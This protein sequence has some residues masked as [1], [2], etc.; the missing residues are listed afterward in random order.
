[1]DPAGPG[2]PRDAASAAPAPAAAAP[3]PAAA[4]GD[5]SSQP[6]LSH[7]EEPTPRYVSET[8]GTPPPT[9][10]VEGVYPLQVL[11]SSSGAPAAAA[12]AVP[13]A[14]PHAGD[15]SPV[16][17][18]A[19]SAG[20]ATTATGHH[21]FEVIEID[22][23]RNVLLYR[24]DEAVESP[25]DILLTPEPMDAR[26]GARQNGLSSDE[27]SRKLSD[28]ARAALDEVTSRIWADTPSWSTFFLRADLAI[29]VLQII[30][31]IAYLATGPTPAT[32]D[33]PRMVTGGLG[34]ELALLVALVAWNAFLF[35][36]QVEAP[37]RQVLIRAK[38][39]IDLLSRAGLN[40]V[41]EIKIPSVPSAPIVKVVRDGVV[42]SIPAV[43][44][45]E[46][47]IVELHFG[48]LA[49]AACK[50][51]YVTKHKP[52]AGDRPEYA[53]DSGQGFRPTL[54]GV[55]P[56]Q[57]MRLESQLNHGRFQFRLTATPVVP[58]LMS[59]AQARPR[60]VMTNQLLRLQAAAQR[61]IL[62]L[63]I[64]SLAVALVRHY[65]L[66]H[67]T[68]LG[69]AVAAF[70]VVLPLVPLLVPTL[71][72]L[73]RS[74][75][76]AHV[77]VLWEE[78]QT[79]KTDYEDADEDEFDVEAPPPTKE[80]TLAKFDVLA[81]AL[82]I[83]TS[84]L[85]ESLGSITVLC[86]VDREGTL[87]EAFPSVD[88]IFVPP[89]AILDVGY[90]PDGR[91][92]FEDRDWAAQM[93][94]LK[95]L[96]LAWMC[97][98][99]CDLRKTEPHRN[100][101]ALHIHA[102][103]KASRQTC[104]CPLARQI[105][106]LGPPDY[107]VPVKE[108]F[109]LAPYHPSLDPLQDGVGEEDEGQA[110]SA[111]A[112]GKSTARSMTSLAALRRRGTATS[113]PVAPS[114]SGG[115]IPEADEPGG[116]SSGDGPASHHHASHH[117]HGGEHDLLLEYDPYHAPADPSGPMV[118]TLPD[119]EFEVP[120]LHTMLL[121]DARSGHHQLISAGSVESIL[122]VA[123]DVWLG[124]DLVPLTD[125]Q[126][127][128]I[129][130]WYWNTVMNDHQIVA[131]AYKPVLDA[132]TCFPG[133]SGGVGEDGADAFVYLEIPHQ[134]GGGGGGGAVPR[135]GSAEELGAAGPAAPAPP[136]PPPIP[137]VR[138]AAT[139][140]GP[141]P[142]LP[143]SVNE[144]KMKPLDDDDDDTR[145]PAEPASPTLADPAAAAVDAP[146][147][148][149]FPARR[150]SQVRAINP[151]HGL[152]Q[153][154]IF[155]GLVAFAH[156]P[157]EDVC[158]AIEDIGL[159]GIRFVYFSPT[160]ERQTK[161]FGERLGLD[162]GW[163]SCILLSTPS[164][165]HASPMY[166]ERTDIK[167]RL[168]RGVDAIRAHLHDVDDI[169]LHVSLFAESSPA[170]V[171]GM[172]RILQEHG[173]VVCAMGSTLNPANAGIF[174]AAD[175]GVGVQPVPIKNTSPTARHVPPL[176]LGSTLVSLPCPL[177]MHP[178]TSLY[179]FTQLVRE[180]R[181]LCRAARQGMILAAAGAGLMSLVQLA[182][183]AVLL[184]TWRA[185]LLMWVAWVLVPILG[186]TYA[187]NP[188]EPETMKEFTERNAE[189][190]RDLRRFAR[191]FVWRFAVPVVA[192]VYCYGVALAAQLPAG[193]S[194]EKVFTNA[195]PSVQAE[196]VACTAL[197]IF[198]CTAS[199]TMV[200]RTQPLW[201][202][203]PLRN[204]WWCVAVVIILAIHLAIVFVFAMPT[205]SAL[206]WQFHAVVFGSLPVQVVIHEQIKKLDCRQW[207]RFQKRSKLEFNT[208]LGMHSPI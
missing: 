80:V 55:P 151:V 97:L 137:E 19:S 177:V 46:G 204:R 107:L 60:T 26:L 52:G 21:N 74:F 182:A 61:V 44:L 15:D 175:L 178:D 135:R 161:A 106:F 170:S 88:Q 102:H 122:D 4:R 144:K 186:A 147:P 41:Q 145:V 132:V 89:D 150:R 54:F 7:N 22:H 156:E 114:S 51:V 208:R 96:G 49:P 11:P 193:E 158:D 123:T 146:P 84:D 168:P 50:Y 130:E 68:A 129:V 17:T 8:A 38:N 98:T 119:Y 205:L 40:T 9:A 131:Y 45:V 133:G 166:M 71:Y 192:T 201:A 164:D 103:T 91:F 75:G 153:N 143:D 90:T 82:R 72:L 115:A 207:V 169:P 188:H 111:A 93:P 56:P 14:D 120:F 184:P 155:L 34:L 32:V 73:F 69:M 152:T 99:H 138:V 172:V 85:T 87:T 33:T 43:L 31:I 162:T 83:D 100:L 28:A 163:N 154:Q 165:P 16:P 116:S 27:A 101:A 12:T 148:P 125:H 13:A 3:P 67:G 29:T 118:R 183:L 157:K 79:S 113:G 203:S 140:S 6:L 77:S 10:V 2:E 167:A 199:A 57:L 5:S 195:V 124:D 36:S 53:L 121:Q 42:R 39:A 181:R 48:D 171:A 58:V 159:A 176:A 180:A 194:W 128:A 206:P 134:P 196:L 18:T 198:L 141:L 95:P 197:V 30:L 174:R 160:N 94:L 66:G 62:V 112:L 142:A 25:N 136:G 179:A 191:Y 127:L 81:Q 200:H 70:S 59:L 117:H 126:E 105:G 189:H 173:E 47:D 63:Y 185:W 23:R 64:L 65:V 35:Y 20:G 139:T 76:N 202:Y 86:F 1:M 149:A 92:V 110:G 190:V 24:G 109:T 108:I 37:T 104:L 187:S 78:L